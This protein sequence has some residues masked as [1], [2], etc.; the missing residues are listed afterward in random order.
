MRGTRYTE[1]QIAGSVLDR[2][3]PVREALL[4]EIVIDNGRELTGRAMD[5]WA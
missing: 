5:Q 1:A 3:I 2:V 4:Q